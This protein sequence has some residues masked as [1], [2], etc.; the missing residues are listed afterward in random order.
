M[1]YNTH[2]QK[3]VHQTSAATLLFSAAFFLFAL[4]LMFHTFSYDPIQKEFILASRV[5]S[6]FAAHIPLIRSF[7]LGYN[8]PPEYPLFPGEPIRYHF[9][10][11]FLVGILEYAGVRIDLALNLPSA[12]GF[13]GL[14]LLIYKLSLLFTS[15]R[16]V[17]ILAVLFFLFNGTLS[18]LRFFEPSGS[19]VEH[20]FTA[21]LQIPSIKN[22]PSFGPWDGGLV[23]AFNN[24]NV[25]TNQRHLAP[26][27]AVALTLIYFLIKTPPTQRTIQ[28]RTLRV[29]LVSIVFSLLLFMNQAALLPTLIVS[30]GIFLWCKTSRIPL[31]LGGLATLP[32]VVLFILIAQPSGSPTLQPGYLSPAPFA[33]S[34]FLEFWIHNLGVHI[35]LIPFGILL[36]PKPFRWF[37]VPLLI[38]FVVPNLFKLSTDMINNHK[39]F[40]FFMIFGAIY[41]SYA[42]VVLRSRLLRLVG[43]LTGVTKLILQSGISIF[44]GSVLLLLIFS[45]VIDLFVIQNDYSLRL[46]DIPT[47]QDARF[48][49]N[50]TSSKDI[51]LNSTWFYHP[52]SLA[53]RAIY[54]GYAFF[55]W[56]AGY[57][58]YTRE[59]LVKTIY[60]SNKK[61]DICTLLL[62][63]EIAFVELNRQPETFIQPINT[64]WYTMSPIF[65]DNP[66][67]GI[68]LFKTAD[69]CN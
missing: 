51:I 69:I 11:Y 13:A 52:A 65:Y 31:L 7:S 17:G 62:Q 39:L 61:D 22:F 68:T 26:S 3:K 57:D 9:L 54:N 37:A 15:K 56:S 24:L 50:N 55:T 14:L 8:W 47:N 5:W 66:A 43:R 67:S 29:A 1:G 45:G 59:A 25:Y 21:L 20:F 33:W 16:S 42:I 30:I 18:F 4:W 44:I 38:I 23:T 12:V 10:F 34:T 6:D 46:S 40:N 32:A 58:T 49:L 63:E 60:R 35:V 19:S 27:F 64:L 53:G 2:M 36:F 48:I 28:Q 41:S